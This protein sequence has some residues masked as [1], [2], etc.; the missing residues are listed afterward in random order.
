[1]LKSKVSP[2]RLKLILLGVVIVLLG[3]F[4]YLG[5]VDPNELSALNKF[6]YSVERVPVPEDGS[7][8]YRYVLQGDPVAVLA[9]LPHPQGEQVTTVPRGQVYEFKL[10]S[11]RNGR[12]FGSTTRKDCVIMIEGKVDPMAVRALRRIGLM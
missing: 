10:P 9:E 5:R 6:P 3:T 2:K 8:T 11:G 1:M 7:I 12:F 4:V